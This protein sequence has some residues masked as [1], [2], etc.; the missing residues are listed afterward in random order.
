MLGYN[1][2]AYRKINETAKHED[3]RPSTFDCTYA[4]YQVKI[5]NTAKSVYIPNKPK[6]TMTTIVTFY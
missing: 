4:R 2:Y 1:K 6:K 3:I 5:P